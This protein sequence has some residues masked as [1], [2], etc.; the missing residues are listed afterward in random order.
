M[1]PNRNDTSIQA[2]LMKLAKKG[3]SS[4][5]AGGSQQARVDDSPHM[6]MAQ[7]QATSAAPVLVRVEEQ[8]PQDARKRHAKE[9]PRRDFSK[10][11]M[12]SSALKAGKRTSVDSMS[13]PLEPWVDEELVLS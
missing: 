3:S 1:R 7:S 6:L 2:K 10:R 13:G 11:P 9:E 4:G 5:S 12:S 8:L